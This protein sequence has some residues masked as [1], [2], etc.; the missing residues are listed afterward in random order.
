M[1]D[2]PPL[3]PLLGGSRGVGR[4][5]S[6]QVSARSAGAGE[7]WRGAEA[8]ALKA[9]ACTFF[10]LFSP[11]FQP[12]PLTPGGCNMNQQEALFF[13]LFPLKQEV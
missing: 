2:N 3:A 6:G 4:D 12:T 11:R 1:P 9:A 5:P 7:G 13:L 8:A 10:P